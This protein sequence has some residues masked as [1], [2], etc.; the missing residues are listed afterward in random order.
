MAWMSSYLKHASVVL[1]KAIKALLVNQ[2]LKE[3]LIKNWPLLMELT[4]I[5]SPNFCL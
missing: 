3:L 2:V 5:M 4:L 1:V